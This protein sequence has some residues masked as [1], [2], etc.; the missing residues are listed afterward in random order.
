MVHLLEIVIWI[1]GVYYWFRGSSELINRTWSEVEFTKKSC[2]IN[3]NRAGDKS[4]KRKAGKEVSVELLKPVEVRAFPENDVLCPVRFMTLFYDL[5][6][7]DKNGGNQL[8]IDPESFL[9]LNSQSITEFGRSFA[10]RCDFIDAENFKLHGNRKNGITNAAQ[11]ANS[12][13]NRQQISNR[14]RHK[15]IASSEVYVTATKADDDTFQNN[16]AGIKTTTEEL[17]S[18]KKLSTTITSSSATTEKLLQTGSSSNIETTST[19]PTIKKIKS[20]YD[21]IKIRL[22]RA[23][24]E[25]EDLELDNNLKTTKIARLEKKNNK[26]EQMIQSLSFDL[27]SSKSTHATEIKTLH[28][29]IDKLNDQKGNLERQAVSEKEEKE[30]WK[31]EAGHLTHQIE[32]RKLMNEMKLEL[33][34][35]NASNNNQN[36]NSRPICIIM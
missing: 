12:Y 16:L 9:P 15:S 2:K 17:P 27:E 19:S 21:K 31:S 25:I 10:H 35:A 5:S 14:A 3:V 28:Q 34:N 6:P 13:T 18:E 29:Q 30:K 24:E 23:N 22:K 20:D 36:S 11:Q 1:L 7:R 32:T 33:L 4:L 8:L 26:Q